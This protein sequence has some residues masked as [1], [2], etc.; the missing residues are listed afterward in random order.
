MSDALDRR[1]FISHL[2]MAGAGMSL[3]AK[4]VEHVEGPFAAGAKVYARLGVK[5]VINAAGILTR[6]G[7]SLIPAE[8]TK[9]MDDASRQF[10]SIPELQ[11]AAGA[12]IAQLVGVEAALVTSGAAAALTLGTAACVTKGDPERIRRIPD[13]TGMPGV[14]LVQPTH[15]HAFDHAIRNVGVRFVEVETVADVERAMGPDVAMMHFLVY[16]DRK[17]KIRMEEWI[18]LGRRY[19]VPNFLDAAADIPPAGHL[20]KFTKMGFDLVA[21][22]GGKALRGPQCSGL[23][24]GRADLITWA[25]ANGSPDSDTIGRGCKVGKE[26]IV[27]L[28]TALE[29]YLKRDHAADAAR[30]SSIVERWERKLAAVRGLTV[31]RV[32]P[33]NAGH[34]PYLAIDWDE[35]VRRV[36]HAELVARLRDG[37]PRIWVWETSEHRVYITPFML[38]RGEDS[39]VLRR[40]L[41]ELQR[42][43]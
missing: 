19:G 32:A 7:G 30:W 2:A 17:G 15:R 5:P 10:V 23:L 12:R 16:A 43:A 14:V 22:S 29:L 31:E 37:D 21:F 25:T 40:V 20:R 28:V 33:E 11:R 18:A 27:G 35:S 4:P 9:A 42:D 24:L 39:I 38:E 41:E 3:D 13:I 8:V 34:V 6:I 36:T 26:E 1:D